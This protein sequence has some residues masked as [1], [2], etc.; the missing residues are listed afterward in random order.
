MRLNEHTRMVTGRPYNTEGVSVLAA[1]H[2]VDG[3]S[4]RSLERRLCGMQENMKMGG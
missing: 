3:K 1:E 4:N 2:S